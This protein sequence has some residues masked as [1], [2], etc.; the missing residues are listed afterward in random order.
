MAK[1]SKIDYRAAKIF[2]NKFTSFGFRTPRKGKDFTPAQKA[3]ITKKLNELKPAIKATA[4]E[5]A[6]FLRLTKKQLKEVPENFDYLA[7]TNNGI[8]T[9]F[10][11]PEK[12]ISKKEGLI[13]K[14][15]IGVR[16]EKFYPFP[17][18][19]ISMPLIQDYVEKL[20]KKYKPDY[21][22]WSVKGYKG[23]ELFSTETFSMYA[24]AFGYALANRKGAEE[25]FS[26]ERFFNGVFLGWLK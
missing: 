15:K 12:T 7:K 19:L 23:G 25:R 3:V 11:N 9:K 1:K 18:E 21:V 26:K 6:G 14:S 5:T 17:L 13:V 20:I 24:H 2:L 22:R 10:A 4:K 16:T 8:F